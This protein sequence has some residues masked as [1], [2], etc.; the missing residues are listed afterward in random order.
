MDVRHVLMDV[1]GVIVPGRGPRFARYLNHHYGI[2]KTMTQSFFAGPF[3]ACL[4]GEA[5]LVSELPPFLQLWGWTKGVDAFRQ[6]W[7]QSEHIVDEAVLAM[8]ANLRRSGIGVYL[9]T[10][11]EA[12]RT[13]YLLKEMGLHS[14]VDGVFASALVGHLKPARAYFD[15]V[16][17]TIKDDPE[18]VL[19]WDDS[20]PNVVQA[21]RFGIHAELFRD[22]DAFLAAMQR[23]IE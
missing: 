18:S 9:A 16:L 23:F 21:R 19:L 4:V 7:F 17:N 8:M 5:D 10:N 22:A 6:E 2:T 1:D 14:R 12:Y 11:Q 3:Q 13:R 20:E 15:C